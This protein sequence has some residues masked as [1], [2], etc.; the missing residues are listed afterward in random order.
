MKKVAA[1]EWDEDHAHD[2]VMNKMI[3][4]LEE[5]EEDGEEV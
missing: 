2:Q 5:D 3:Q 1:Y 4:G